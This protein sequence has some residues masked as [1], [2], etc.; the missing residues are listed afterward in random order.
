MGTL[1][2]RSTSG[3]VPSTPS[4]DTCKGHVSILVS[5]QH[6]LGVHWPVFLIQQATVVCVGAG[7]LAGRHFPGLPGVV[8]GS[9]G[10]PASALIG[11]VGTR[12]MRS[13]FAGAALRKKEKSEVRQHAAASS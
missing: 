6:L 4:P 9:G 2:G 12:A 1:A 3:L 11:Q 8:P 13:C 5:L 10:Q 7:H